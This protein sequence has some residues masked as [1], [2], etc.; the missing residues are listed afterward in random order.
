VW[1]AAWGVRLPRLLVLVRGKGPEVTGRTF[2]TGLPYRIRH[3]FEN[4]GKVIG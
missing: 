4:W 3:K 1:V 2:R